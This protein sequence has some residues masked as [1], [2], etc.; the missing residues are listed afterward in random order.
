MPINLRWVG[1]DELDRVAQTRWQCYSPAAK[2]LEK[3]KEGI[4]ADARAQPGDFLLA[5]SNR[6][7]VGT[8]TSMSL[9]MWVRGGRVPCQGVAYV[10]TI[11]TARRSGGKEKGIATQLM[12]ATLTKAREREQVVSA[13]MPFRASFYEHFGYGMAE[14]RTDWIVPLSTIASGPADVFQLATADDRPAAVACRQRLVERG[15]CDIE[16]S[17]AGWKNRDRQYESGFE[18]VA[19]AAQGVR[20]WAYLASETRDG[21]T[22]LRVVEHALD[23]LDGLVHLLH[24]LGAQRDQYTTAWITLPSDVPL[25]RLLREPQLPHRAVTH[26]FAEAR[27]F[28]RMQVRVLDHKR[29]LEAMT[30]PQRWTGAADVAVRETEGT[31]SRLRIEVERGHVSVKPSSATPAIE[32]G[33]AVWASIVTGNVPAQMAARLG[34]IQV[35]DA[36]ASQVLEAFSDGPVPFCDEYF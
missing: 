27:P 17:A 2:E 10:G 15:Q 26:A 8:T 29:F 21:R 12:H 30:L 35:A 3:F 11:P 25:N 31:V 33:D 16:T 7:A 32:C 23:T 1:E 22:F 18:I 14:R 19:R 24:F 6:V 34:L 20:A 36:T 5:E 13:L 9:Q 4:R 28:T